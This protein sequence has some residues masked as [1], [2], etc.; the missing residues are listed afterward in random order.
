MWMG[1]RPAVMQ[2]KSEADGGRSGMMAVGKS[3]DS[4]QI[5]ALEADD[6]G[7]AGENRN[8]RL[9]GFRHNA[10]KAIFVHILCLLLA[11][12][13]YLLAHWQAKLKA[14]WFYASAAL[15]DAQVVLVS[16]ERDDREAPKLVEVQL[17]PT[18]GDDEKDEFCVSGCYR[19]FDYQCSRYAWSKSTGRFEVLRGVGHG[20]GRAML[21]IARDFSSGL[22]NDARRK[23]RLLYGLNSIDVDVKSHTRLL[24]QE[25][26][27]PFYVFQMFSVVLWSLD[28]Y[29]YYSTCILVISLISIAYTLRET[30]RQSEALSDLASRH[31]DVT[32]AVV[33]ADGQVR[34]TPSR[35]L[36]PGD[37]VEIPREGT[38]MTCDALL[39][40]GTCVV[41]ESMLTGESLPLSKTVV[42]RHELGD[43]S[44]EE[45]PRRVET[46]FAGTRVLQSGRGGARAVVLNTG[47]AT[48]KGRLIRSILYP[49]AIGLKFY[50]DTI[51]FFCFMSVVALVGMAYAVRV[52]VLRGVHLG[53]VLRRTLDLITI[54]IPPALPAAMTVGTFYAQSRLKSAG[55]FSTSP[56]RINVA[57]MLDVV[58]FDKTGTLTEDGLDLMGV[59]RGGEE[60]IVSEYPDS[61]PSTWVM[62]TCHS[63]ASVEGSTVKVGDPMEQQMFKAT[64]WT[65][66][67]GGKD[68]LPVSR[69]PNDPD[70]GGYEVV[71][72]FPYSPAV[73]R[74]T[75]LVK[76]VLTGHL[77]IFSKGA[78]EVIKRLCLDS[79]IPANFEPQLQ[80]LT[81]RGLR[82]IALAH[83]G[84]R[85]D[86]QT[87][88]RNEAENSLIFIGFLVFHNALKAGSLP[89]IKC[90]QDAAL[91]CVIVTGDNVLTALAVAD[92]CRIVDKN[93]DRIV[94]VE[95]SA[96]EE[97]VM[98]AVSEVSDASTASDFSDACDTD[99]IHPT[100]L[101]SG[102][103]GRTVRTVVTGTAWSKIRS[104]RPEL[105]E[106]LLRS[107]AVFAR[108][109]PEQ[110]R[111]LIEDLQALNLTV[112]MCGDGANDCA[113]LRAAHVGVSL[114]DAEASVA[115]PFTATNGDI[116][117]VPTLVREGRCAL[118]TSFS[119]FKYMA[120]YSM[121]QFVAVLM[122]YTFKSNFGDMQFLY[123]DAAVTAVSFLMVRTAALPRLSAERPPQVL[124]SPQI[125][126]SILAQIAV[127]LVVQFCAYFYLTTQPWF[128]ANT[129]SEEEELKVV[130]WENSAVFTV[131]CLQYLVVAVIFS[132][133]PPFRLPFYKNLPFTVAVIVFSATSALLC[134][135]P[136]SLAPQSM[137]LVVDGAHHR[138]QFRLTL[139][140]FPILNFAIAFLVETALDMCL[141]WHQKRN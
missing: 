55:I 58:C 128:R 84:F 65:L 42:D 116:G 123:S 34:E 62:A 95:L 13:P 92:K 101:E 51:K 104:R 11:G 130:C 6:E 113:A 136:D 26:L 5:Q 49:K 64:H 120:L 18:E 81:N 16:D 14:T 82:L 80:R 98:S 141:A 21:D 29:Y 30:R 121:I 138:M 57:G 53:L 32:A 24:F 27:N 105:A 118:V 76:D 133:G 86:S 50:G 99:L 23:K 124:L 4:G 22:T 68:E 39:V 112:G 25:V 38:L 12:L 106:E 2:L 10:A 70:K 37:V 134:L 115:A 114:S 72:K 88:T 111:S 135:F 139:L 140:L 107:G 36:V 100:S 109:T 89:A 90:L 48:A 97:V 73:A 56:Q 117:C 40:E 103:C 91:R 41:N 33:D 83:K 8:I 71:K 69:S 66:E 102:E 137:E 19:Y 28:D 74:M 126:A 60:N 75:V 85:G 108:M 129:L 17:V 79:S 59:V 31:S 15:R 54:V 61:H 78:P 9:R 7:G 45:G 46:L 131:S 3:G 67:D 20:R 122:L 63:L 43:V 127:V 47:F 94:V 125:I 52:Y 77:S 119:V 96:N 132:R 44:A 35:N 93:R 87:V 110:K 1:F